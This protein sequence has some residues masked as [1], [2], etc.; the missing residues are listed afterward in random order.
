MNEDENREREYIRVAFQDS[1]KIRFQ[2][3]TLI[4]TVF[5]VLYGIA[6]TGRI[7]SDF[8]LLIPFIIIIIGMRLKFYDYQVKIAGDY[9]DEKDKNSPE[10]YL[11]GYSKYSKDH[12][13]QLMITLFDVLPKWLLFI[14]IPMTIAIIY[15]WVIVF[16]IKPMINSVNSIVPI[17]LH[18]FFIVVFFIT[19]IIS[20]LYYILYKKILK[21]HLIRELLRKTKAVL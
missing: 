12:S 2:L 19:I 16:K 8:I 20:W 18:Q 4:V 13:S 11:K 10:E 6:L 14:F 15:S 7:A 21:E 5:G 1:Q 17:Y 9:L 3:F